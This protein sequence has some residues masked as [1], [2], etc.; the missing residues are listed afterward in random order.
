MSQHTARYLMILGLLLLI[1]GAIFY[2]WGN[3]FSWLGRLPG[4]IR[5]EREGFKLYI[6]LATMLLLSALLNFVLWLIRKVL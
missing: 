4:D 1:A 3:K 5:I 2:F 6:P